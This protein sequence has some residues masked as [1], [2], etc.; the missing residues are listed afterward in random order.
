MVGSN[1]SLVQPWL[2]ISGALEA[3]IERQEVVDTTQGRS[4]L[5]ARC[6]CAAFP[7]TR[8]THDRKAPGRSVR[9]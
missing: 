6:R 2:S 7:R 3:I 4:L 5:Y 9:R 8:L 1:G